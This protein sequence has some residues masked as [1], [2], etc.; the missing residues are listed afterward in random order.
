[1][2][3][4]QL[5]R[6]LLRDHNVCVTPLQPPS[7]PYASIEACIHT[8]SHA[9]ARNPLEYRARARV[10]TDLRSNTQA[11]DETDK[12]HHIEVQLPPKICLHRKS[13]RAQAQFM[14][15]LSHAAFSA[16]DMPPHICSPSLRMEKR[17]TR[18]HAQPR[19][20]A[21]FMH[22]HTMPR[23]P[24]A[25]HPHHISSQARPP[26]CTITHA[27]TNCNRTIHTSWTFL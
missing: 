5:R 19:T 15:I 11:F 26:T 18:V 14:V 22:L 23:S 27:V 21:R 4:Y 20:Q 8:D 12:T 16:I 24:P 17:C 6:V 25:T 13:A 1:V 3:A 7:F 9:R 2:G 10:L